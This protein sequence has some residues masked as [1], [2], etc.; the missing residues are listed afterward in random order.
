LKPLKN[1]KHIDFNFNLEE[2]LALD[3]KA[4]ENLLDTTFTIKNILNEKDFI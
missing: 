3:K 1:L 2:K 4:R